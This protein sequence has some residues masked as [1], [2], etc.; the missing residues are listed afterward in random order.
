MIT[1]KLVT[2]DGHIGDISITGYSDFAEAES[3][4]SESWPRTTL[5]VHNAI[6]LADY[7]G[8][9]LILQRSSR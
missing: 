1:A 6:T 8:C 4:L 2:P 3:A 9:R 7:D 5:A